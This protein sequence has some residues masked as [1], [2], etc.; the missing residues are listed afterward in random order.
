MDIMPLLLALFQLATILIACGVCLSV[1]LKP[2]NE[3]G[4]R[5]VRLLLF[6]IHLQILYQSYLYDLAEKYVGSKTTAPRTNA[7]GDCTVESLLKGKLSSFLA[8]LG[9]SSMCDNTI[10]YDASNNSGVR[11]QIVNEGTCSNE[12]TNEM[13]FDGVQDTLSWLIDA[14]CQRCCATL[15]HDGGWKATIKMSGDASRMN[16]SIINCN[17]CAKYKC[18][19]NENSPQVSCVAWNEY[20]EI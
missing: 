3:W 14:K 2:T 20:D 18:K 15:T 12:A 6:V 8:T 17:K 13:I 1:Q 11:I 4:V 9:L 16:P 7:I 10:F 19:W 5:T